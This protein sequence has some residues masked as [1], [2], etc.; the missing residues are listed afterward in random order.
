MVAAAVFRTGEVPVGAIQLQPSDHKK[1]SA[2]DQQPTSKAAL[3]HCQAVTLLV[4]CRLQRS[5]TP[6]QS[7]RPDGW[8][9]K[10]DSSYTPNDS[11]F[12][13]AVPLDAAIAHR[14]DLVARSQK[15]QGGSS[16]PPQA[17]PSF[18]ASRT[19]Q[20]NS[21]SDTGH[22]SWGRKPKAIADKL[23]R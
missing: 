23:V 19:F 14:A 16:S 12:G 21:L 17:N 8:I 7:S 9:E 22:L 15:D 13:V 10:D 3:Y 20:N 2:H 4:F 1:P 18:L 5:L 6:R 11:L